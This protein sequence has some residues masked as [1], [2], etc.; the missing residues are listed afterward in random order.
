MQSIAD[1]AVK[2]FNKNF[3][4]MLLLYIALCFF[5][6]IF[7]IFVLD[8][9]CIKS[10]DSSVRD[11]VLSLR[12]PF[13]N[14]F[15]K[16]VTNFGGFSFITA[17]AAALFFY[18][19]YKKRFGFEFAL[20]SSAFL[21]ITSVEAIKFAVNRVRPPVQEMLTFQWDP[22]F[23]SGHTMAA[24]AFYGL[25]TYFIY[26]SS[27]KAW[28][29]VLAVFVGCAIITLVAFSRIYLG[30]HWPSDVVGSFIL[31]GFL[32]VFVIFAFKDFKKNN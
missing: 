18:F 23:P 21:A 11:F 31:G 2:F 8:T 5:I 9:S 6:Y 16:F 26:Y 29:R 3:F 1:S 17:S 19:A 24:I 15:F 7:A 25:L 10:F 14:S 12:T 27:Q 30:V 20:L 32:L 28:E 22:S 4:L 13:L